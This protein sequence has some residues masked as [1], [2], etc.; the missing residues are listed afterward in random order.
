MGLGENRDEF[1]ENLIEEK[2]EEF[3]SDIT[4]DTNSITG[5]D[6]KLP[7]VETLDSAFSSSKILDN[8]Q[9]SGDSWDDG[10]DSS[11]LEPS[12]ETLSSI[13]F[14][15]KISTDSVFDS[16]DNDIHK[17]RTYELN[18]KFS[19]EPEESIL[20]EEASKQDY[21]EYSKEPEYSFSE[22]FTTFEEETYDLK[23]IFDSQAGDL[24]L[25][26]QG[27]DVYDD[28]A[29]AYFYEDMAGGKELS[30]ASFDSPHD[31][32]AEFADQF[33][34]EYANLVSEVIGAW[35]N[36]PTNNSTAPLW[37][38]FAEANEN[39]KVPINIESDLNAEK[40]GEA[41]YAFRDFTQEKLEQRFG[42]SIVLYRALDSSG[43]EDMKM[44]TP[45]TDSVVLRHRPVESWT[46][47]PEFA[48]NW[49]NGVI[50]RKE[51]DIDNILA[52]QITNPNFIGHE[53]EMLVESEGEEKY[54]EDEI[55]DAREFDPEENAE[56]ALSKLGHPEQKS[57]FLYGPEW[58]SIDNV[59][60]SYGLEE[61]GAITVNKSSQ[62]MEV[63]EY[64]NGQ[65]AFLTHLSST[66]YQDQEGADPIE[67]ER[68]IA[69]EKFFENIGLE[70][71]VPHHFVD[72]DEGYMAVEAIDGYELNKA[73]EEAKKKVEKDDYLQFAA[74][75]ILSGNSDMDG[76]NTM[77]DEEGNIYGIDIDH[78]G[79]DFTDGGRHYRRGMNELK[80]NADKLGL[81]IDFEDIK[82]ATQTVAQQLNPYD[83]TE[84]I[85]SSRISDKPMYEFGRNIRKNVQEFAEA[86]FPGEIGQELDQSPKSYILEGVARA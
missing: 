53:K 62:H 22:E 3:G 40:F 15:D 7:E 67:A 43:F 29:L 18:E 51:V 45:E 39:F 80:A 82:N 56:W 50:L 25:S 66:E 2:V 86:E 38:I 69:G 78:S 26:S 79:G 10:K 34:D 31:T 75:T 9:F 6:S 60:D 73:P 5:E 72:L 44:E 21:L 70:K 68:A 58:L 41:L 23:S 12:D 83:A 57:D 48:R 65:Q 76:R 27:R 37:H 55:V 84:D 24:G 36:W 1:W 4:K 42:D 20:L 61:V 64:E 28:S 11:D 8:N 19:F 33:R 77:I 32:F 52:S 17:L 49:K 30:M 81:D 14:E 59:V 74:A 13:Q 16:D 35:V 47:D 46:L 63:V 71:Y 54:T 85:E